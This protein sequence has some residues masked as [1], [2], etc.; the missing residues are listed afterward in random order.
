MAPVSVRRVSSPSLAIPDYNSAGISDTITVPESV[1]IASVKVGLDITHTYPRVLRATLTTPWGVVVELF[2]RGMGGRTQKGK[3]TDDEAKLPALST[4]RG[5]TA[6]ARG[7]S[8]CRPRGLPTRARSTVGTWASARWLPTP[9]QWSC[10]Y[11]RARR[12]RTTLRR[13]SSD[14]CQRQGLCDRQRQS[15]G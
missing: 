11:H 9:A 7:S 5:R 8:R 3:I 14:R 13:T 1:T 15:L 12:S 10:R 4:L 6:R 2:P